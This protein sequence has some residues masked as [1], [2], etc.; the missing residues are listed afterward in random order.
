MALAPQTVQNMPDCLRPSIAAA[1]R[2]TSA[3][4]AAVVSFLRRPRALGRAQGAD[5]LVD[6][7][8]LAA[9]FL[10]PMKLGHLPLRL[11]QRR[12]RGNGLG[13]GLARDPPRQAE[14][15]AITGVAR[16]GALTV[17]LAALA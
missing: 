12:R 17:G 8:D 3:L 9:Q 1:S 5:L 4:I 16:L 13:D 11:A 15:G 6:F 14:T 10:K 2:S 7:D